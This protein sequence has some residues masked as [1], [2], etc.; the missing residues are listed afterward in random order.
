MRKERRK[1]KGMEE[2]KRR[3]EEE[4]KESNGKNVKGKKDEVRALSRSQKP[5]H[6]HR[7][8]TRPADPSGSLSNGDSLIMSTGRKGV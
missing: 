4:F 1:A 6:S 7:K 8:D 2:E 5:L 3:K